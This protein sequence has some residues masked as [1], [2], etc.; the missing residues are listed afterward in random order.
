M[1]ESEG[2]AFKCRRLLPVEVPNGRVQVRDMG[3]G[4]SQQSVHQEIVG[5]S[6]SWDCVTP[7]FLRHLS[8][9]DGGSRH[10]D[11]VMEEL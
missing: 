1:C 7:H 4:D 3:C 2:L 11:E 10:S 5:K 9:G 8:D 6:Y